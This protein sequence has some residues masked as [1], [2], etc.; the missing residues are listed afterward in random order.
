MDTTVTAIQAAI[1]GNFAD[2]TA[3]VTAAG[4]ALI[5]LSFLSFVLRKGRAAAGGK[6]PR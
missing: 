6:V 5:G 3:V 4:L 1:T 2:A